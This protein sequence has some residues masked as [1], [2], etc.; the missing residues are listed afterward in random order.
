MSAKKKIP[1]KP[2]NPDSDKFN[3]IEDPSDDDANLSPGS[4]AKLGL[5]LKLSERRTALGVEVLKVLDPTMDMT[6]AQ[7]SSERDGIAK[8][9]QR[10]CKPSL[11][12]FFALI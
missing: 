11:A 5:A 6:Q 10:K 3:A 1:D 12:F 7:L 4:D 2:V 9:F 8:R